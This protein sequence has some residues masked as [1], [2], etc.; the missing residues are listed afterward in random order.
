MALG[1]LIFGYLSDN[2][3]RKTTLI[4]SWK[5]FTIGG[6][7]YPFVRVF[8]LFVVGYLISCFSGMAGIVMQVCLINES[9]SKH[10]TFR[11]AS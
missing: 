5:I 8:P 7:I 3:G 9:T 2:Q 11:C 6:L 1:T 4:T 10:N